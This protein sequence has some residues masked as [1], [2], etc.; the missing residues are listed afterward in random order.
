MSA[1]RPVRDAESNWTDCKININFLTMF[2][3]PYYFRYHANT[4]KHFQS[5]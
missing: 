3:L 4:A 2:P 5:F 1:E